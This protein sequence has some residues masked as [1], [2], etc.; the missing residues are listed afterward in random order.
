[1]ST[2][3]PDMLAAVASRLEEHQKRTFVDLEELLK[4]TKF[5]KQ[6]IR[7]MYRGFKQECPGGAVNEDT[8]KD[9]YEKFFPYGNATCYAH[10]VF[11]A[12]DVTCSGTISFRDMLISLSTLLHGTLVEK[13]IWTFRVYDLNGDGVI[14]KEEMGNVAVAVYELMGIML[15]PPSDAFHPTME[16]LPKRRE[17]VMVEANALS[18][19]ASSPGPEMSAKELRDNVERAFTRLDR[20]K[21]GVL[22]REEFV[23]SCLQNPD[24]YNSLSNFQFK[25]L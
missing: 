3:T 23:A 1:M 16:Y 14:T 5:S 19:M 24:I 4:S 9:I 17:S 10:H 2:I 13:L 15:R 6:E 8:F 20:N 18:W 7:M 21:D 25:I 12:F 22:T 11:K